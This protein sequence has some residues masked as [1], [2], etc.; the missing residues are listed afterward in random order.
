MKL[1]EKNKRRDYFGADMFAFVLTHVEKENAFQERLL[2]H[3]SSAMVESST[4]L[5]SMA[6]ATKKIRSQAT[7]HIRRQKLQFPLKVE[8]IVFN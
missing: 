2:S 8:C 5:A 7:K 6:A 1:R 3:H 4:E